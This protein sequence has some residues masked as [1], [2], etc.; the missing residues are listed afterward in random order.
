M[1]NLVTYSGGGGN[2]AV[3]GGIYA[4]TSIIT[5]NNTIVWG[6]KGKSAEQIY[7]KMSTVLNHCVVGDGP[8]DIAGGGVTQS[9][10]LHSD[11]LFKDAANGDYHLN[12]ASPCV[13]AGSN[14]LV[15]GNVKTDLDGN[16]RIQ[17]GKVDIGP[18]EVP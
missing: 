18:Y 2:K 17:Q 5:L 10:S 4:K 3:G 6:N 15:P 13:N 1:G 8:G 7:S 12:V 9:N 11:P 16:A 14:A